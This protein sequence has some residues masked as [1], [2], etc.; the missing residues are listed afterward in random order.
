MR[1]SCSRQGQAKSAWY[2]QHRLSFIL[3]RPSKSRIPCLYLVLRTIVSLGLPSGREPGPR[4]L[5]L[6]DLLLPVQYS[7]VLPLTST[8]KYKKT[9][10]ATTTVR[11]HK[12]EKNWVINREVNLQTKSALFHGEN[13]KNVFISAR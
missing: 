13:S 4:L 6:D 11:E 1:I 3:S 8:T 2:H 9:T 7:T 10:T 12:L 5:A